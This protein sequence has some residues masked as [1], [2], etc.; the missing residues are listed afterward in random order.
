MR[1]ARAHTVVWRVNIEDRRADLDDIA[2]RAMQCLY[3]AV[4]KALDFNACLQNI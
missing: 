3:F 2:G 1:S 4:A